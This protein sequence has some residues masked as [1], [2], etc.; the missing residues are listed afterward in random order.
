MFCHHCPFQFFVQIQ[1]LCSEGT[2]GHC[3]EK[4]QE[5][6]RIRDRLRLKLQYRLYEQQYQQLQRKEQE[7]RRTAPA[8]GLTV[9][10]CFIML[11]ITNVVL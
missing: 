6:K 10:K 11:E 3:C 1:D 9:M 2:D 7:Q 8:K 4:C 5:A